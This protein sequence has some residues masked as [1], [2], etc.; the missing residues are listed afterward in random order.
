[1]NESYLLALDPAT[2]KQLWRHVRPSQAR[3]ESREAFTTPVPTT[4][5]G[6]KQL[7]VV[8]GDDLS[9]HDPETGKELWR[10]GTWNPRRTGDWRLVPSA[11]AGGDVV[12]ACAPK[13][14]PIYAV[15]IGG[16]GQLSDDALAWVSDEQRELSSDV[17]TP[18]FYDGDFFIL[19]DVRRTLARVDPR[20]GEIKWKQTTPGRAKY[21]ASPTVADG[22]VYVVNFDG[23][24]TIFDATD[25]RIINTISMDNPRRDAVR[26][27]IVAAH[28]NLFIRT[29]NKL[30]CIGI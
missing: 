8:G 15:T 29:T 20:T 26:A 10:W 25:G 14:D 12:L 21:E 4:V 27:T 13:G 7:L 18:A 5:N 11:V 9:G 1:V 28:G 17:P 23:D 16:E 30:Y 6:T 2:G 19:G 24:V 22:K 3:A